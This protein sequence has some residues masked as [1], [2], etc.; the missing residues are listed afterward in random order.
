MEIELGNISDDRDDD[1]TRPSSYD[2]E[3]DIAV[4][5]VDEEPK[6]WEP[7]LKVVPSE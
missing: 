3:E 7:V 1:E 4:E 6:E 5:R 2:D